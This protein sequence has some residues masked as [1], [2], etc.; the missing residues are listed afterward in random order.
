MCGKKISFSKGYINPRACSDFKITLETCYNVVLDN[1]DENVF[2]KFLCDSCRRK[3]VTLTTSPKFVGEAVNFPV[4]TENCVIC[5][6]KSNLKIKT[7]KLDFR[8][9][10]LDKLML[11]NGF[12]KQGEDSNGQYRRVYF[13][14]VFDGFVKVPITLTINDKLEWD[15]IVYN[16]H[17]DKNMPFLVNLP[18]T[19]SDANMN[20]FSDFWQNVAICPGN[21]D[22]DDIIQQRLDFKQPFLNCEG[23]EVTAYLENE[24]MVKLDSETFSVI[25]AK[26]CDL[27]V[28]ASQIK[29]EKCSQ[30]R[31]T[32][33]QIRSRKETVECQKA[34]ITSDT[35]TSNIRYLTRKELE[36]RYQ[37]GRKSK[38]DAIKKATRLSI[39]I[40]EIVDKEG[41]LVEKK[42]GCL[43]KE[44]LNTSEI[45]FYEESPRWLLWQQQKEQAFKSDARGMRWHPLIV[46][47]CLSIYH[48]S[49]AAY[50]QVYNRSKNRIFE[51]AS[52]K[53]TEKVH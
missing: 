26:N 27:L 19:L 51:I 48:T 7:T 38:L 3:M 9:T 44:I 13:K 46:R 1:E 53:Y 18:S 29:C 40:K 17:L 11:S 22:C 31:G 50:K 6:G 2:P 47:W 16:N 37:N 4:H 24:N 10:Y 21:N 45:G 25:R 35:S 23:T 52:Y 32:L 39:R 12:F 8:V 15:C 34:S 5:H 43:M 33:R 41:I 42:H 14:S 36:E 28:P 30:I 20:S 49:P